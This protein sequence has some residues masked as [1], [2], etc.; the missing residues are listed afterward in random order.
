[1]WEAEA[2][3]DLMTHCHGSICRKSHGGVFGTYVVVNADRFGFVKGEAQR[4]RS[5]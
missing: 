3:F 1:V 2:S 5:T 4:V